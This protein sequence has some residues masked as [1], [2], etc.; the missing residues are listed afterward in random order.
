MAK[1]LRKVKQNRWYKTDAQ[2]L[3]DIGDVPADPL[4]DLSTSQNRL[5][6]FQVDGDLAKI[7]RIAR[8]LAL[9]GQRLDD[10]GYVLFDA[11]LLEKASIGLDPAEGATVDSAVNKCHADLTNL[12]GHKLVALTRLILLEGESDTVLKKRI[13]E[14]VRE[15]LNSMELPEKVREKLPKA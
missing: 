6:V 12:T 13:V 8:A 7:E 10:V 15:G 9:G 2:P 14:L 11:S 1:L 5:S 4:G 3:L